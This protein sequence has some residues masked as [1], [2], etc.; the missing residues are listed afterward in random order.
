MNADGSVRKNEFIKYGNDLYY[1]DSEG[2][3]VTGD[4]SFNR[5]SY[6]T[7]SDG[8]ILKMPGIRKDMIGIMQEKMELQ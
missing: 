7:D 6:H 3:M 1:V 8:V 2:K 5:I 4:F